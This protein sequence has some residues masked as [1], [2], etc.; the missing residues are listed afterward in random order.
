MTGGQVTANEHQ[1]YAGMQTRLIKALSEK[2]RDGLMSGKGIGYALA[3]ELNH[4]P[5]PRH[6]LD[7]A[8]A[9]ELRPEQIANTQALFDQM[10]AEAISLGESIVDKETALD[11]AFA[12]E[13]VDRNNL[14]TL[15]SDIAQLE[16]KLRTVHLAT[17]LDMKRILSPQQVAL[18]DRMRGYTEKTDPGVVHKKEH[19]D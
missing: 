15:V 18:Y 3:A 7:M 16:G 4:Y 2:E 1:P 9:L 11:T 12:T 14:E 19:Q 8:E 5:G 13:D 17:H 6:V 10:E